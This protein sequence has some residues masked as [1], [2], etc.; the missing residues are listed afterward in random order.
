MFHKN[1]ISNVTTFFSGDHFCDRQNVLFGD[2]MFAH[3][4]E[5]IE[6]V[7]AARSQQ[8]FLDTEEHGEEKEET[9]LERTRAFH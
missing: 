3:N 1:H 7:G 5:G 2:R 4:L 6:D 9:L 8:D